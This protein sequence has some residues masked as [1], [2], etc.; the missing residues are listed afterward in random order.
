MLLILRWHFDYSLSHRK[1]W[2]VNKDKV[3]STIQVHIPWNSLHGHFLPSRVE[4]SIRHVGTFLLR[5]MMNQVSLAE[6]QMNILHEYGRW[7]GPSFPDP[8]LSLSKRM[9][10]PLLKIQE[11]GLP[12]VPR[13]P[14]LRV[15]LPLHLLSPSL[16]LLTTYSSG[17]SFF[18][19]ELSHPRHLWL[20]LPF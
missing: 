8:E 13:V 16:A 10:V 18:I 12:K 2:I 14:L 4:T 3:V 17:W 19:C 5:D 20:F 6:Q 15:L 9:P 11:D 1:H 7:C